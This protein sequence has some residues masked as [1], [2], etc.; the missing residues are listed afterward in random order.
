VWF[1]TRRLRRDAGFSL[2]EVLVAITL[3]GIVA[4]AVLPM[5]LIGAR[6]STIVRFETRG[7]NLGQERI[8]L[9]RQL[10]Y[11]IDRQNGPFVDLLDNYYPNLSAA[12]GTGAGWVSS[13]ST[14]R[15]PGEPATGAFYRVVF[16]PVPGNP[17]YRQTV[18]SQFLNNTRSPV[19]DSV[20][21]TYDSQVVGRDNAPSLFLGVT[22]I[23]S[24]TVGGSDKRL[25]LFTQI[26]DEGRVDSLIASQA[27]A[28]ALR[29]E[30]AAPDGTALSA[31]A[32]SVSADGQ[33]ADG[34]YASVRGEAGRADRGGTSPVFAAVREALSPAGTTSGTGT[35]SAV[36]TD[37][38]DCGYAAFGRSAIA[39]GT[40]STSGGLP[41]VPGTVG[42]AVT[43]AA[44]T[45]AALLA[46]PGGSCGAFWFTNLSDSYDPNL[47]LRTDRPLVRVTGGTSGSNEIV[48]GRGWLNAS[49]DTASTPFVVA[50]ASA[51][52]EEAVQLLPTTFVADDGGLIQVKL[53]SSSLGCRATGSPSG[54]YRVIISY[55][56]GTSRSVLV[57]SS[58][59]SS[60]PTADPLA[61]IDL[62]TKLVYDDG[63]GT[64][65]FL[66]DYITSWALASEITE[67]ATSGVANIDAVLRMT[68]KPV[69][70]SDPTS[71]L[72]IRFGSLSCVAADN[73]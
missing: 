5:L 10:P 42:S 26:A 23:T 34:S 6:A 28:T 57:D 29:V 51:V 2:V 11:Q 46:N 38:S 49:P 27:R 43:P 55:W 14:A 59:S 66:S 17:E 40:A 47:R 52:T 8:E 31:T 61:G 18:A 37:G 33:L 19:A 58:W 64:R 36:T 35:E 25:N 30:S 45:S 7:K 39:N 15:L 13:T 73:R 12:A 60:S 24:W 41:K 69:R 1:V 72:G 68:T 44:E 53:V 70:F 67:G 48:R 56:N 4:A 54:S 71:S 3:L 50:G 65:R 21:S 32:G 9:M 62:T 22:V 63:A 16:N 20:F